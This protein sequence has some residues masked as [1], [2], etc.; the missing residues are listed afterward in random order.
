MR[1]ARLM[2]VGF[3]MAGVGAVMAQTN[4]APKANRPPRQ[5]VRRASTPWFREERWTGTVTAQDGKTTLTEMRNV[6]AE[7]SQGRRVNVSTDL[8]SGLTRTHV[9]DPV[10]GVE[11]AWTSAHPVVKVLNHAVPVPGRESCW[12]VDN[13]PPQ[14]N[15]EAQLPTAGFSCARA[16]NPMHSGGCA[17]PSA[18]VPSTRPPRMGSPVGEAECEKFLLGEPKGVNQKI[19]DLGEGFVVGWAVHGC[20]LTAESQ[21]PKGP[22]VREVW[23]TGVPSENNGPLLMRSVTEG[24]LPWG[25]MNKITVETEVFRNGGEPDETMFEP[26]KGYEIKVLATTEVSC[27]LF[28]PSGV[29]SAE[30]KQG[31]AAQ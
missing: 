21:S 5:I 26:P 15:D 7:D 27:D 22:I 20:R 8:K 11:M 19:E 23:I 9:W 30:V 14:S 31:S 4:D 2:A 25:S 24:P 13:P 17:P 6:S 18:A 1:F 3:V 12:K 29:P 16:E 10:K 28:R